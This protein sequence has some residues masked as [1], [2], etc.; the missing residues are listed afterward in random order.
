MWSCVWETET[1]NIQTVFDKQ[2][3]FRVSAGTATDDHS[4]CSIVGTNEA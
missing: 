2:Q 1:K 4:I 3:I